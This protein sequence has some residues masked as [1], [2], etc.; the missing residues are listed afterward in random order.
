MEEPPNTPP[1]YIQWQ[2]HVLF[3]VQGNG[4]G[5]V[6]G[7]NVKERRTMHLGKA[8]DDPLMLGAFP[9]DEAKG[10]VSIL[11][12]TIDKARY[13]RKNPLWSAHTRGPPNRYMCTNAGVS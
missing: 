7:N 1:T 6:T 3:L 9:W 13:S 2:V 12:A 4:G 11:G 8:W 5:F 10:W